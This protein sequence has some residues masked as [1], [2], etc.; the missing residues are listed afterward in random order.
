MESSSFRSVATLFSIMIETSSD[1][2]SRMTVVSALD[3][4]FSQRAAIGLLSVQD[5]LW[6][7]NYIRNCEDCDHGDNSNCHNCFDGFV[8]HLPHIMFQG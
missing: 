8:L 2:S 7:I 1:F 6:E 4:L 3:V 5:L